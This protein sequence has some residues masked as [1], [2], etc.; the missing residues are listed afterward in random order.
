M[1]SVVKNEFNIVIMNNPP[2]VTI[3]CLV[4]NHELYLRQCLDGF[5][6]Q[7]TN[8]SFKV[9]VHDDASTDRSADIIREY[10]EK[11]PD[12]IE[13]IFETENQYSKKDG[14]LQRIMNE[15]MMGKYVAM[16]E[17]D[18]FWIDP[19][20]LQKQVDFL[21]NH[22][23]CVYSCHRYII[24]NENTKVQYLMPNKYFENQPDISEFIFDQNYPFLQ[25]W[26]TKTLTCVYR[27]DAYDVTIVS[28]YK[29]YRD[30]H[31]V[32]Y[33]LSKGKG[34]CHSFI[35]GVYR[36][37]S[38]GIFGSQTLINQ[39]KISYTVYTEMYSVTKDHIFKKILR[40]IY[41]QIVAKEK[42][43][44]MPIKWFELETLLIYLPYKILKKC[45]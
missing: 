35:G 15:H 31:L 10:A 12:I 45:L 26:V 37:N 44:H 30:V 8:F 19:Y 17:G 32:Y 28:K 7:K 11:Y 41:L 4:Y 22:P 42:K 3:R 18:D 14:S 5:M 1:E 24:Y 13:P 6:M 36:K 25:E 16:C 9:I 20:K 40:S 34:V 29:Y 43:L 23:E 39:L 2:L 21:E 38:G 27:R 33:L